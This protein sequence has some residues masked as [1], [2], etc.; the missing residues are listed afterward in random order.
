M[1]I[2]SSR[3]ICV[4][5]LIIALS[6]SAQAVAGFPKQIFP[7]DEVSFCS[8]LDNKEVEVA[9]GRK[10]VKTVSAP[11]SC[12]WKLAPKS[13]SDSP[14]DE[15]RVVA[16]GE[17]QLPKTV[18][19]LESIRGPSLSKTPGAAD[20]YLTEVD[21]GIEGVHSVCGFYLFSLEMR[22]PDIDY[23]KVGKALGVV[24]L[25]RFNEAP[26]EVDSRCFAE[27][28][29]PSQYPDFKIPPKNSLD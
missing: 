14:D 10:V 8:L 27:G 17:A 23:R 24:A 22:L 4:L 7:V 16:R 6:Y 3:I 5:I 1:M 12:E 2:A 18:V 15:I 20:L 11:N 21:P 19:G 26:V 25:W 28:L 13:N 29:I 9:T